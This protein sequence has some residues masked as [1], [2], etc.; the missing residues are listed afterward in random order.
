MHF[1]SDDAVEVA[2]AGPVLDN[3][4][5]LLESIRALLHE[6]VSLFSA[7]L[8]AAIFGE[9]DG[10]IIN[11]NA[12]GSL[13][14]LQ[15]DAVAADSFFVHQRNT[16]VLVRS[17]PRSPCRNAGGRILRT[18]PAGGPRALSQHTAHGGQ[19]AV[20]NVLAKA[21]RVGCQ[22]SRVELAVSVSPAAVLVLV[23]GA[24]ARAARTFLHH[25]V[26]RA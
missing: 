8:D 12:E 22:P 2:V 24:E 25:T 3:E 6:D 19:D 16:S 10:T 11:A 26:Q 13:T 7:R 23:R 15:H 5:G 17:G 20:G 9:H 18:A 1:I 14:R 21:L 4:A